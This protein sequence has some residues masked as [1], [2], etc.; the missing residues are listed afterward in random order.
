MTLVQR[1]KQS[2]KMLDH[3]GAM[4]NL[5]P[6]DYEQVLIAIIRAARN[7]GIEEERKRCI[8]HTDSVARTSALLLDGDPDRDGPNIA[9]Q[10]ERLIKQGD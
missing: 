9:R 8:D 6:E 3:V 7:D 4:N 1:L 2:Q 10:I 5:R